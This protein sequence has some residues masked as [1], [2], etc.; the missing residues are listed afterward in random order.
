MKHRP[1]M[2]KGI[3]LDK[4]GEMWWMTR[5][6][7]KSIPLLFGWKLVKEETDKNYRKRILET[8]KVIHETEG[9]K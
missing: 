3:Y 1:Y 6:R 8:V 7:Y 2:A 5:K 9:V 4:I